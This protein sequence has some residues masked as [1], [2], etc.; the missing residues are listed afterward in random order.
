MAIINDLVELLN[1]ILLSSD[2]NI[3]TVDKENLMIVTSP[4]TS[5]TFKKRKT[6]ISLNFLWNTMRWLASYDHCVVTSVMHDVDYLSV[7]NPII[8][9]RINNPTLGVGACHN[10][11]CFHYIATLTNAQYK[12]MCS[13]HKILECLQHVTPQGL[14][15]FLLL[16]DANTL[17]TT[18]D[19]PNLL[20]TRVGAQHRS[21]Y[22]RH[23]LWTRS[24]NQFY[25]LDE[26]L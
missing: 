26:D 18:P 12:T 14:P 17:C 16:P 3:V 25:W 2:D 19:T 21:P 13:Q 15:D 5:I 10:F 9:L 24:D 22:A 11:A 7:T 1:I 4:I 8:A 20:L 6:K 23:K